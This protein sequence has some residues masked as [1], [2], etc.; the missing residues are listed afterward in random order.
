[1]KRDVVACAFV[2]VPN[3]L[4]Y[5]S[6]KSWQN[7][8]KSDKDITTIKRVK[9]F[10]TQCSI[11]NVAKVA[12]V[13]VTI[14]WLNPDQGK[15][16][17]KGTFLS[18]TRYAILPAEVFCEARKCAKF[19]FD[20]I[21]ISRA[22]R[23]LQHPVLGVCGASTSSAPL[24]WNNFCGRRCRLWVGKMICAEVVTSRVTWRCNETDD[25]RLGS[26][27][28]RLRSRRYRP[29]ALPERMNTAVQTFDQIRIRHLLIH[30]RPWLKWYYC[31][32]DNIIES[33]RHRNTKGTLIKK[34][35]PFLNNYGTGSISG[36]HI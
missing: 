12:K 25:I 27:G 23:R 2:F 21:P 34:S 30:D 7:R 17:K 3:F 29:A 5:V 22:T 6:G 26:A 4:E 9:F 13:N 11:G 1:M 35:L 19:I 16:Q 31:S 10:E 32:E 24:S 33:N 8:I 20:P 18:L 14:F 36:V 15:R 28:W